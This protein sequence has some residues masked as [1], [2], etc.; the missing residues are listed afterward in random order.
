[1]SDEVISAQGE[2][3]PGSRTGADAGRQAGIEV[4]RRPQRS[5]RYA[6]CDPRLN[7][8]ESLPFGLDHSDIHFAVESLPELFGGLAKKLQSMTFQDSRY[9]RHSA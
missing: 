4:G 5:R 1:M 9:C 7:W 8:T 2:L 6:V 3:V